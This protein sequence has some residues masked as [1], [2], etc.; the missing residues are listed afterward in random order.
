MNTRWRPAL[1]T[2][3]AL[4]GAFAAGTA[5]AQQPQQATFPMTVTENRAPG[6]AGQVTITPVGPAQIRV[7]IRITG[8]QPNMEHAAHIHTAPGARCDNN[9]PVTYPLTNVR[10]DASGVGTSSTVV[11]LTPDK[12]VQANNA[13]VNVH[14]AATPPGEGII[15]ADIT[16]TYTAETVRA[17]AGAQAPAPAAPR[18][19]TGPL[20]EPGSPI[21]PLLGLA[22]LALLGGA[23][24]TLT[25]RPHSRLQERGG[26]RSG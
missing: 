7:D 11:Q 8:L 13:Y 5:R 17:A 24:A 22:V 25:S 10:V 2:L 6:A 1:L 15:C 4:L 18:T 3:A 16:V 20:A 21:W 26:R 19:G 14:R 12:P 23:V 9:A